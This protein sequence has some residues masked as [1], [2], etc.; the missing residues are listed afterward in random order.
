MLQQSARYSILLHGSV[1]PR[2]KK[3]ELTVAV[4]ADTDDTICDVLL[5]GSAPATADSMAIVQHG[6]N[7][8][9]PWWTVAVNR[10]FAH[11]AR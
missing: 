9:L 3:Q 10:K 5:Q 6:R 1:A 2:P 7:A 8:L 4:Y 11:L